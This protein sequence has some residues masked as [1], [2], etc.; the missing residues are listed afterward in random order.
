MTKTRTQITVA[1]T[2]AAF[3]LAVIL[4]IAPHASI[5]TNEASTE[6]FGIDVFAIT[7]DAKD[8]PVQQYAAY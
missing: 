3:I 5:A 6:I 4:T 7:T 8:L 2:S 1:L